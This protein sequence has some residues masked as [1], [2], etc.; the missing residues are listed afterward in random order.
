MSLGATGPRLVAPSLQG[1]PGVAAATA[2]RACHRIHPHLRCCAGHLQ[3]PDGN[4]GRA[5]P[6]GARRAA[7][8]QRRRAPPWPVPERACERLP[9]RGCPHLA[10]ALWLP[11]TR[12]RL[13]A[14]VA[15][16]LVTSVLQYSVSYVLRRDVGLLGCRLRA[17]FLFLVQ[18]QLLHGRLHGFAGTSS[19]GKVRCACCAGVV[20]RRR[21]AAVAGSA[22]GRASTSSSRAQ[23][24]CRSSWLRA[25]P[26]C[27]VLPCP[28]RPRW[29]P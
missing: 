27:P 17:Q 29:P 11:Y 3:S 10:Q 23:R 2:V 8:A 4:A 25:Q 19:V 20:P 12:G 21:R 14:M 5:V 24:R 6:G 18:R 16:F 26:A 7:A 1:S 13:W 28:R 22:W 9:P 15:T